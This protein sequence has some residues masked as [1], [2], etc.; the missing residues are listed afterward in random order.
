MSALGLASQALGADS[1]LDLLSFADDEAGNAAA[2]AELER[3]LS[4]P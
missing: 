4:R 1:F 2:R 3:L